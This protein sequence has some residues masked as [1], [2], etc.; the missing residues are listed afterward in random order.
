MTIFPTGGPASWVNWEPPEGVGAGE[1]TA[2]EARAALAGTTPPPS[3]EDPLPPPTHFASPTGGGDGTEGSPFLISDFLALPPSDGDVLG[4]V[5]SFAYAGA[6][7]LIQPA[8]GVHGGDNRILIRAINDGQ[9]RIDGGGDFVVNLVNNRRWWIQGLDVHNG[10]TQVVRIADGSDG[11]IVRRTIAWDG[12]PSLNGAIWDIAGSEDVLIEDFGG[13]GEGRRVFQSSQFHRAVTWRR[14][15]GMWNEWTT[16][17]DV[18]K[19]LQMGYQGHDDIAENLFMTWD[20]EVDSPGGQRGVFTYGRIDKPTGVSKN[21]NTKLLGSMAYLLSGANPGDLQQ[22]VDVFHTVY[23]NT[24][25]DVVLL[26]QQE[27]RR[28]A[29]LREQ[30]ETGSVYRDITQIGSPT[31]ANS[32]AGGWTQTNVETHATIG[33]A[34]NPFQATMGAG[35]R[36]WYRYVDGVLTSDPL[37]PWP[38]DARLRAAL[39]ASGRDPDT[40]F[41]G[42]GHGLTQL[43][44]DLFSVSLS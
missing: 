11:C 28:F 14:G 24:I 15:W 7:S 18:K 35:A 9:V 10:D 31:E 1:W 23:G 32:V 36:L 4:L 41:G 42:A 29:V 19:A 13:F 22:L 2:E 12:H 5:D 20:E 37:W 34:P 38:M 39:T 33:A 44:E 26:L 43:M 17:D 40:I 16:L 6:D 3:S 30:I 21:Q 8:S 25:K 27:I